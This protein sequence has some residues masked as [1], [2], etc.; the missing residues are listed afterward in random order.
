MNLYISSQRINLAQDIIK[1]QWSQAAS[2]SNYSQR[3]HLLTE[4]SGNTRHE[5]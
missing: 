3:I 1:P 2:P 5:K 4:Q